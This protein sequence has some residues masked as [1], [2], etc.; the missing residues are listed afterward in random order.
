VRPEEIR[1][2]ALAAAGEA[3]SSGLSVPPRLEPGARVIAAMSGGVDSSV[4][5]ALLCGAGLEVVGVSMRLASSRRREEG[6]TGCCS[7]D[8]F[9]DARRVARRLG[10]PHYVVDLRESFARSVIDVFNAAYLAGR[11]P[12]P[13]TLCNRDVKLGVFREY[14]TTLA[15]RAIAT[16]HYAR[17]TEEGEGELALRAARDARKD[18]S[19]FLFTLDQAELR[20][21]LFPLGELDKDSVRAIARALELPVAGKPESQDV[22]F[23]VGESYADFVERETDPGRRRAGRIIDDAGR[24]IGR[25]S[26]VHRFTV[27][28]R[29]G[30]GGGASAPRYVLSIDARSGDVRVGPRAALALSGFRVREVR[31]TAQ[32]HRGA[33]RVRL[34]H[35]HEPVPCSLD[36]AADGAWVRFPSPTAGVTPGQAAVWYDG[37]RVIGGG[38]I[39]EPNEGAEARP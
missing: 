31:W 24:E 5:A 8:D 37:D 14:A 28:Q 15:A 29:R 33:A 34:R 16:G 20:Q 4:A 2:R 30:V 25:H 6:H 9:E 22:C 32:P 12:N 3:A 21:T 27:G 11:T 36:P 1:E 39:A 17:I 7:L 38:W 18:Q 19:Y 10:I 26:G 35:R 23:V 13:C